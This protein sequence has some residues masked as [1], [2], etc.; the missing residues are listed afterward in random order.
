M[1]RILQ[2]GSVQSSGKEL[3]QARRDMSDHAERVISVLDRFEQIGMV[4]E[5]QVCVLASESTIRFIGFSCLG[6]YK[7]RQ[8]LIPDLMQTYFFRSRKTMRRARALQQA[9]Q[10][11]GVDVR[12]EIFLSDTEPRRTWGWELPQDELTFYCECMREEAELPKGWSVT[13]WS[14]VEAQSSAQINFAEVIA[15]AQ[16]SNPLLISQIANHLRQFD[17]IELPHGVQWSAERQ[18]AAYA[19]EGEVLERARPRAIFLQSEQ[20]YERKDRLYQP[21]RA[22]ALPIIHPF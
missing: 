21:R 5:A 2:D 16:K 7:G 4:D 18:V 13:L 17:M 12:V 8:E 11:V 22:I 19:L 1:S 10:S 3:R 15:W 14:E 20:P 9:L 6:T